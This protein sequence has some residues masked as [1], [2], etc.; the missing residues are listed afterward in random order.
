MLR[1]SWFTCWQWLQRRVVSKRWFATRRRRRAASYRLCVER[2][3]TREL[4]SAADLFSS[5]IPIT[6]DGGQPQ[7]GI[8]SQTPTYYAFSVT[9]DGRLT[10]EVAATGGDTRLSL[11][12]SDGELLMQSDGQ[13]PTNPHDLIDV[14]LAGAAEGMAYYLT[15]E[16]L[17][18]G[19]GGF[20][21]TTDYTPTTTPFEPMPVGIEP[22]SSTTGDFNVDG[23]ADLAVANFESSDVSIYLGQG[24]GT[25]A[26]PMQFSTGPGAN[27][28]IASDFNGDGKLDLATA[29]ML[30]STVSIL[31]GNDDGT[32]QTVSD[33]WAGDTAAGLIAADFN[34]DGALDLAVAAFGSNAAAILLNDGSGVFAA[35]IE[36]AVGT[37][38]YAITSGDFNGDGLFDL[39]VPNYDSDDLSILFGN[40]DGTF[41]AGSTFPVGSQPYAPLTADFNE[42][43]NLDLAIGNFTSNDVSILMGNGDGTFDVQIPLAAGI[44]TGAIDIADFN[45]DGLLDLVTAN[46]GDATLSLFLGRA[47]G[48]FDPQRQFAAGTAPASVVVAD[49]NRDG[50][51]DVGF[52]DLTSN[53][54]QVLLGRGNA[55]F[56]TQPA[57][58]SATKVFQ[59]TSADF[60]GDGRLD[61][62]T[63]NYSLGDV[64]ILLGNQDGTFQFGGRYSAGSD[65]T[66]IAAGDVNSDGIPD[67][68]TGNYSTA[69]ISVLLGA[70]DGTFGSPEFFRAGTLPLSLLVADLNEDNILDVA[71]VNNGD[72]QVSILIGNGD[73]QF[74]APVDYAV[75]AGA[76]QL[77]AADLNH[78]GRLDL[79]VTNYDANSVSILF[80]AGEGEFAP[81][82]QLDTDMSPA[83]VAAG[84]FNGD[85]V[86]DLAVTNAGSSS[87][88]VFLGDGQG[89]FSSPIAVPTGD[90]PLSVLVGDFNQDQTLDLATVNQGTNTVT[91]HAGRGDG[92]FHAF[93]QHA[94]GDLVYQAVLGDFDGDGNWD[95]ATANESSDVSVLLGQAD[96]T[97]ETPMHS[98]VAGGPA[99]IAATDFNSDGQQ[100]LV[101]VNPTT[102]TMSVSLGRGDGTS[103]APIVSVLGDEPIAVA[104]DDFNND[105]RPDVA[106]ANYLSN[107]VSILLGIGD[108]T[109]QSPS[110]WS[111]GEH[112]VALVTG[113]FNHD[114]IVDLASSDFGNGT[115][116]ILLGRV[117][118]TFLEAQQFPVGD[119]PVALTVS[120]LNLDGQSDLVVAN[121][122]SRSLSLLISFG[123]GTFRSVETLPLGVTPGAVA[124][125][126]FNN[127]GTLDITATSP[128]NNSVL[129]LFGQ[130]GGAFQSPVEFAVGTAPESLT[131]GDFNR[132]GRED[133]ATANNNSNNVTVLLGQGDGTFPSQTQFDVGR[134]PA[135]L[136]TG[137]FNND[138]RLDFAT[139]NG[140]TEP[141][142]VGL[143]LGNGT[144]AKPGASSPTTQ[145]KPLVADLNYD[146]MLDVVVLRNDGKLLFRAGSAG[147]SFQALVVINPDSVDA[148]RDVT[149][150]T[151]D[152]VAYLV[153]VNGQADSIAFYTVVSDQF[154]RVAEPAVPGILPSRVLAGDVSGD[155]LEDVIVTSA[156]SGRVFVYLQRPDDDLSSRPPT[157]QI[158]VGNGGSDV[159]LVD[160]NGDGLP[161]IVVADQVS[162][163][164][165]VLL[166]SATAPFAS[167][168]RFR[169][170]AGLTS[171]V[172]VGD[173]VQVQSRDVSIA[174]V[175]GLFNDDTLPDL[176]VLNQGVNRVDILLGDG[177]GGVFNPTV[178]ASLL[179]G[180]DPV[181]LVTA[182]FNGD[183]RADLVVLN[184][185]SNDLSIFLND[186][187]GSFTEQ[188]ETDSAGRMSRVNAGNLPTGLSVG[189]IN[190][191]GEL[192]LLIG[193]EQG[194]VL[195][196]LGNGDGTFR[197]YQRLDRHVGLAITG[198]DSDEGPGF[199]VFDQSLDRVTYHSNESGSTFEQ[200]REN[201]LL[202]PTA[203]TF[204]DLNAD[205]LDDLIVSNGGSNEVFVY[206]GLDDDQFDFGHRFF[207]GSAPEEI[208]VSDLNA[209]GILDLVVAN[210]GSN[211]VSLLFGQG[212][213]DDWTLIAGPRL[214]VGS[215]PIATA[216][217]DLN[218][219]GLVDILVA[220][221]DSSD[222]YLLTGLGRG[223]FND[224][225]PAVS[226]T[227]DGPVQLFI[228]HFDDQ[229]G[230]D[231]VTLNA[232]SNDLTIILSSGEVRT[233]S[234]GETAAVTAL[235]GDLN[236]DGLSDLIVVTSDGQFTLWLGGSNGP[237]VA[238]V[239]APRNLTN[240][241]EL[242]LGNVRGGI[243]EV[244]VATENSNVTTLVSFVLNAGSIASP[245]GVFNAGAFSGAFTNPVTENV[246]L[247][248]SG[249]GFVAASTLATDGQRS[250]NSVAFVLNVDSSSSIAMSNEMGFSDAGSSSMAEFSSPSGSGLEIVPILTF[251]VDD[252]APAVPTWESTRE[253][254]SQATESERMA[255]VNI[256]GGDLDRNVL[257]TGAAE[258]PIQQ[259]LND[260]TDAGMAAAEVP[261]LSPVELFD[262]STNVATNR[263]ESAAGDE[264]GKT[265]P[266]ED[267]ADQ[268]VQP[269][270]Q[271]TPVFEEDASTLP[272][273]PG[274]TDD[275][276]ASEN[277]SRV[278]SSPI[279]PGQAAQP[280]F[281]DGTARQ[282]VARLSLGS[283][284]P[285]YVFALA[286]TLASASFAP[287]RTVRPRQM[288]TS[289]PNETN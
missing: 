98:P 7:I 117:D 259:H 161:E 48:S 104:T 219:D 198:L 101:T 266:A 261:F 20:V 8:I 216:V 260:S 231:V 254:E 278:T 61:L 51:T 52:T 194:D 255:A 118:G 187:H 281:D 95:I 136:I 179:T 39:A 176:A 74:S 201:G 87:V 211:D 77:T 1:N 30:S 240:I 116:S 157:Y 155:G 66:A 99:A 56:L 35:P 69:D 46:L 49:F 19:A 146:G 212:Q 172:Q 204:A 3:E 232:G 228:G 16:Q 14:H 207:V 269:K 143:G 184:K 64:L 37:S 252:A 286:V 251:G 235:S 249:S 189:D 191:D 222:V 133:I 121:S 159:T 185:G 174:V 147:G 25:F 42:D 162:G 71:T 282:F 86:L 148:V 102:G 181:A 225:S 272:I 236:Q 103:L 59:I 288:S 138:G 6:L 57:Q 40:G 112:P 192:D 140:L 167:Q 15:I 177:H 5:A 270:E 29:N 85:G 289:T 287:K 151:S 202:A 152:G 175:A 31:I 246:A 27:D 9:D 128:A 274:E 206:L 239:Q 119:G 267:S 227:G 245:I 126:D 237:R 248:G 70:G 268:T 217:A 164:V 263:S 2:L 244:Y 180:R 113:D 213:G 75:A 223:F 73:G 142:S 11:F 265:L 195:T 62:A 241:S 135:A 4:L 81:Q 163:D 68:L 173:S 43:G 120:D 92:T 139:A 89:N 97:F 91:V 93:A 125:G 171:V 145:S 41:T 276:G 105:G 197:P 63:V 124:A 65:P 22:W 137:D 178:T 220:N 193:N 154:V 168:L 144:F 165:R 230:L 24:D 200:G 10:A 132:D 78:D 129:I 67:L 80:N 82:V 100:D 131:V 215:G 115:V 83:G 256:D 76:S 224:K 38:P 33:F 183:G 153:A 279:K 18:D 21:L 156:A 123:D 158:E 88:S 28:I 242:V 243:V 203:V 150:V 55:S 26:L 190:A 273:E 130:S 221:H 264:V 34:R 283:L 226:R 53:S 44:G 47:D 90:Q 285:A 107:S 134:Y 196:I 199:A 122:W 280:L 229:G 45:G 210:R 32:F 23:I 160:V 238:H 205:G 218:N 60:N 149:L 110:T 13:S 84:D 262:A 109:F 214:R 271:K 50:S 141:I 169:S 79:A 247:F 58:S 257:I 108:G 253:S 166:N 186:G 106:I 277:S 234:T 275:V 258:M 114:D 54:V 127:D 182:D 170:G 94:L 12:S 72:A 209:D 250:A 17:G 233:V 111:V 188:T 96:G 208:T 36:Y 284:H